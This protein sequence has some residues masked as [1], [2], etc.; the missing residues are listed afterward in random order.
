MIPRA[1]LLF[2]LLLY[3]IMPSFCR[4]YAFS[5]HFDSIMMLESQ[6]GYIYAV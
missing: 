2:Y 1:Y 3:Y 6:G 5:R 4:Q